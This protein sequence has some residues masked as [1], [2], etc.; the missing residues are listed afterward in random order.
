MVFLKISLRVFRS[1]THRAV[2]AVILENVDSALV[3]SRH[4][5]STSHVENS[6]DRKVI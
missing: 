1:P 3:A 5:T 2:L 6:F 4:A